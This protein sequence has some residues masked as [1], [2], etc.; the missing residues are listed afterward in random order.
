MNVASVL[1]YD[2]VPERAAYVAAKGGV[3]QLTKS[4]ALDCGKHNIRCNALVPGFF[5]TPMLEQSLKDSG[6]YEGTKRTLENKSVFGRAGRPDELARAALFLASDE[7]SFTTGSVLHCDGG[8][9]VT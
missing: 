1:S 4:I 5:L 7:S 6:D 8:W 2:V 3:I 9:F